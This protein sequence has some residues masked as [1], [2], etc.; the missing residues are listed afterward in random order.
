MAGPKL[1]KPK[2]TGAKSDKI[3]LTRQQRIN[4]QHLI[5]LE[6]RI[7]LSRE[8]IQLWSAFF[9]FF[10]EDIYE[11]SITQQEEKAFFQTVTKLSRKQFIFCELMADNFSLGDK[12]M[13]VLGGAVSLMDIKVLDE[14]TLGKL[15]LDCHTIFLEMNVSLGRLLRLRPSGMKISEMLAQADATVRKTRTAKKEEKKPPPRQKKGFL[16]ALKRRKAE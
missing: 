7:S 13:D 12:L 16:G 2:K 3:R 14:A 9:Q 11:R 6:N 8:Y 5:R 15:E 10:A 4:V 1:L